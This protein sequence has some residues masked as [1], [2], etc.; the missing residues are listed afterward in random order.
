M[1]YHPLPKTGDLLWIVPSDS[2]PNR[3][4]LCLDDENLTT[5]D[6]DRASL[7][8]PCI[9]LERKVVDLQV[10]REELDVVLVGG[11]RCI[12]LVGDLVPA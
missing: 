11:I 2:N 6:L 12:V 8:V 9:W 1:S 5:L 3:I 10:D 7:Q 4:I